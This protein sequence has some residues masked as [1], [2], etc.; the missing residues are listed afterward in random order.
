MLLFQFEN[1]T[2]L[3]AYHDFHYRLRTHFKVYIAVDDGVHTTLFTFDYT[4]KT[5]KAISDF[6]FENRFLFACLS[7]LAGETQQHKLEA[8][9][10]V[11][12]E[13]SL[14]PIQSIGLHEL[15]NSRIPA[16]MIRCADTWVT[17][18]LASVWPLQKLGA[19]LKS[20]LGWPKR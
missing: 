20:L 1:T 18:S 11:L 19:D 3:D 5:S 15:Q 7:E 8:T 6:V 12:F 2:S 4:P 10:P 17:I 14:G 13:I 16:V 9:S